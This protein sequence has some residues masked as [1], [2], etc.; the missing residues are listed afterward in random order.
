MRLPCG[1]SDAPEP[2][3]P[4]GFGPSQLYDPA[5]NPTGR[6]LQ[7]GDTGIVFPGASGLQPVWFETAEA[8][9][10][11]FELEDED[12]A[13]LSR[14]EVASASGQ[15]LLSVDAG[16]RLASADL[17]PG[18]YVLRLAA[19][20]TAPAEGTP[21]FIR[22]GTGS[23]AEKAAKTAKADADPLRQL[24]QLNACPYCD[25]SGARL[26]GARLSG[27]DLH[28]INLRGAILRR[29]TLVG[30]NLEGA[31]L[32]SASLRQANLAKANL[33]G[34]D[35]LDAS[36]NEAY[37]P[38]S[39]LAEAQLRRAS[40]EGARME[41]ANLA[42]ANL[43]GARLSQANLSRADLQG[44]SLGSL[45]PAH[46]EHTATRLDRANLSGAYL[47]GAQLDYALLTRAN[48]TDANLHKASLAHA[49][50]MYAD[51]RGARGDVS[52][53]GADL[54][55]AKWPDGRTCQSTSPL[56]QCL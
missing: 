37:L 38:H 5:S 17:A 28:H 16:H 30:A 26:D 4:K 46:P 8:G 48:L 3:A 9:T 45:D 51:L 56:G 20:P 22:F 52:L 7:E 40:L 1:G 12:L 49:R 35:L 15:T 31:N 53:Q 29:A 21:L 50:L 11:G 39:N 10:Y 41:Y 34:A 13:V 27:A 6:V 14:V 44:A 33:S 47:M 42:G 55:G 36:L 24:V 23:P 32:V 2:V 25:L 54:H 18:R 43:A 19:A